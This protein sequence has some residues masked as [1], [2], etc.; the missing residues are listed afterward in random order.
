[1]GA[2]GAGVFENDVAGDWAYQFEEVAS[3]SILGDA[4][5]PI[6]A[7]VAASA[8]RVVN[9]TCSARVSTNYGG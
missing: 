9:E 1:M 7:S 5:V 2:W 4:I 6:S 8:R 3:P